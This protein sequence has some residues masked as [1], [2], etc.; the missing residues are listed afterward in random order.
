[1][2]TNYL[3]IHKFQL[4][5]GENRSTS[6]CVSGCL[7]NYAFESDWNDERTVAMDWQLVCEREHLL[8]LGSSVYYIGLMIGSLFSGFIADRFGRLAILAVC[9][10]AQGTMAVA[11]NVIQVNRYFLFMPFEY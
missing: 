9:L 7:N 6:G 1:M 11:L 3:P 4:N 2:L 10:Y 5:E 8:R